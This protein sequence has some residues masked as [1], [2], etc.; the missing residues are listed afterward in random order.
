[1]VRRLENVV[2][3]L[4]TPL[5]AHER[6][7]VSALRRTVEFLL[8]ARVGAL[9]VLGSNGE[10]PALRPAERR[11][12]AEETVRAVDGRCAVIAGALEPSTARVKDEIDN[13]AGCGLDAYVVTTP[14]Y[15]SGYGD[16]ELVAHFRTVAAAAPAPVL[17]YN[18]PQNTRVPLRAP[19]VRALAG[20]PNI[21]GLKDSSGDWTE[22]QAALLDPARPR[23]FVMLQGMH[24][25]SAASLLAGADG[26]VPSFA[27][28]RP[29]LL[30]DL[31]AAARAGRIDEALRHQA[32]LDRMLEARGRAFLHANK[33]LAARLGLMQDHVTHP[34]PRMSAAEGAAFLDAS[35]AAGFEFP[36]QA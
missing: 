15:Y 6:I 5:D 24:S 4:L 13:L 19:V 32:T 7:D 10:G 21:V 8:A 33:L 23:D 34:M 30:V 18:I 27:N 2:V 20:I 26:L 3:P 31:C 14:Y 12:L 25:L 36:A 29:A 9:F 16:A 1:M 11:R 28:V 17:A 22:F 35:R